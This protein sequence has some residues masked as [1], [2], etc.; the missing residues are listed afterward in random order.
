MDDEQ[1]FTNGTNQ[2]IAN[3]RPPNLTEDFG[4]MDGEDK[5]DQEIMETL[6]QNKT[7]KNKE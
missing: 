6:G 7:E 1:Q 3:N 2:Q 4:I 5:L